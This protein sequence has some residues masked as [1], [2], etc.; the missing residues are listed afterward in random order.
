MIETRCEIKF[1]VED[2][3]LSELA[4]YLRSHPAHFKEI[5][6]ERTV[7]NLYLDTLEHESY[8]DNLEGSP[9]KVKLRFRWYNDDLRKVKFEI[10]KKHGEVYKKSSYQVANYNK[11]DPSKSEM[12]WDSQQVLNTILASLRPA[13]LTSYRRRYFESANRKLRVTLDHQIQTKHILSY[14][15]LEKTSGRQPLPLRILEVKYN[16][17]NEED[18]RKF[19]RN[20]IFRRN[21][22]SKF[23]EAV[24]SL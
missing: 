9:N 4:D 20:F 15:G 8:L 13:A 19:A 23:V 22:F 7:N 6:E 3:T 11:K 10:K 14:T 24:R 2:L 1:I 12:V 17:E 16:V 18:Y 21:K 5:H